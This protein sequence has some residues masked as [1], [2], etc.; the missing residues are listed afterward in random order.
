MYAHRRNYDGNE[1]MLYI[2]EMQ[3]NDIQYRALDTIA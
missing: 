1:T 2:Y 3:T